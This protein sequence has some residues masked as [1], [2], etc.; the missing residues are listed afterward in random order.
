[1]SI[2]DSVPYIPINASRASL[3]LEN[4]LRSYFA[5]VTSDLPCASC[6][7]TATQ[8]YDELTTAYGQYVV[9]YRTVA[10]WIKRFSKE[11]ESLECGPRSSGPITA[12]LQQNIDVVN[13]LVNDDPHISIDYIATILDTV[14]TSLI[15]MDT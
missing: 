6:G 13:A 5:P 7:L 15:V 9:S 2:R 4:D 10:R 14:I 12:L 1:M 8:I 3:Q 11:R